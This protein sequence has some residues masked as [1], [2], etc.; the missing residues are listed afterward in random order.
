MPIP[1]LDYDLIA[2]DFDDRYRVER[3][4][5]VSE[6][7]VAYCGDSSVKFILEAGC[8]TGAWIDEIIKTYENKQLYGLD[9]SWQMLLS[10][11]RKNEHLVLVNGSAER[12][13]YA[14]AS[15]DLVF[16]MNALHHFPQPEVFIH[17]ASRVLNVGGYILIIGTDPHAVGYHW[18]IHDYFE[19]TRQ[20]DLDRFPP[21]VQ[22]R[23]WLENAGFDQVTQREIHRISEDFTGNEV[24]DSPFLQK[25]MV[26]Q[27][28]LLSDDAYQAGLD[29]M[30]KDIVAAE[31]IGESTNFRVNIGLNL[32]SGTK[33][34]E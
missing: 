17:D 21:S 27:L 19:S 7:L 5:G 33:H 10:A 16:C 22:I 3:L 28:A 31:K 24:F 2:D 32:I 23:E 20:L 1:R 13:P 11:H 12:M 30:R 29:L 34:A 25:H 15:F 4:A 18:Y 6:T 9:V 14:N 8:G 26:S